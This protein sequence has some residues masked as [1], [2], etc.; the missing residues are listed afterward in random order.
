MF[1]RSDYGVFAGDLFN[2]GQN[3][4]RVGFRSHLIGLDIFPVRDFRGCLAAT[5]PATQ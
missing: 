5:L 3:L 4:V 2:D 1:F